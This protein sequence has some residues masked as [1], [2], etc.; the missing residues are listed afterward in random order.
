MRISHFLVPEQARLNYPFG[1]PENVGKSTGIR[2][3]NIRL[4]HI[5]P[6]NPN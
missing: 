6:V 1:E 4:V 2:L 5:F 3:G